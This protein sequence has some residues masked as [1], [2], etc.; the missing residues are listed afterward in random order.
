MVIFNKRKGCMPKATVVFPNQSEFTIYGRSDDD[1]FW[2]SLGLRRSRKKHFNPISFFSKVMMEGRGA[3]N[4][5]RATT[6][7]ISA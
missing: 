7:D 1:A 5:P 6:A 2:D 4:W 3:R